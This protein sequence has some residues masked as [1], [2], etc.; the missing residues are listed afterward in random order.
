MKGKSLKDWPSLKDYNIIK[1]AI[2]RAFFGSSWY[3]SAGRK[4]KGGAVMLDQSL[5]DFLVT[6]LNQ[7]TQKV[8]GMRENGSLSD[9]HFL[10]AGICRVLSKVNSG[11]EWLQ[12]N[13]AFDLARSTFFDALHSA[14]RKEITEASC[15]RLAE[16]LSEEIE[17]AG[18]DYLSEIEKLKKVQVIAI[19][20]HEIEHPQHALRDAKDR[21]TSVNTIYQLDLHTGISRPFTRV[22]SD[23]VRAHEWPPFKRKLAEQIGQR[24]K[25]TPIVYVLDRAYIDVKFWHSMK[26]KNVFMITRYKENMNPMMKQP[27]PFD[28]SDPRNKGVVG[29][30]LCGFESLGFAYL[31]EY[32]DPESGE[33]Y[34][35]LSTCAQLQPGEIAWLYFVRWRIEKTF[36]TFENDLE[37]KKAWAT[38]HTAQTQQACFISMAYN[39]L[40]YVELMLDHHHDLKDEKVIKKYTEWIELRRQRAAEKGKHLSMFFD[41][42]KRMAKLSL[43]YIRCFRKHFFN[44]SPPEQYLPAFEAALKSYL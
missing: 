33:L 22:G 21:N 19:D 34:K 18:I 39:F 32:I 43:Q 35:F 27:V 30:Y 6:K 16:I 15:Y 13:D 25:H 4:Q 1:D 23:G 3:A 7:A 38:G 20:G 42:T 26:T 40:R 36:D 12:T 29:C 24:K 37:E 14:R 2:L 5:Y 8:R 31:I 10:M 9:A 17:A 28:R 44:H 41:A 11:R